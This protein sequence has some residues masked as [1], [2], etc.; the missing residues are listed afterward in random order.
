MWGKK[1]TT[2]AAEQAN[3]K[4]KQVEALR[5][6]YSNVKEVHRDTVY[7]VPLHPPVSLVLT[8][9]DGFPTTPPV[10]TVTPPVSHHWVD[11]NM[12]II[13]CP[14]L[15]EWSST[16]DLSKIVKSVSKEFEKTPPR[17]LPNNIPQPSL[18]PMLS[19]NGMPQPSGMMPQ[20]SGMYPNLAS[21]SSSNLR[22]SGG[23]SMF[24]SAATV[25]PAYPPL[26]P[27]P[28]EIFPEL[29]SLSK[30]ELEDLLS[31]DE[32]FEIFLSN[33]E[34]HKNIETIVKDLRDENDRVAAV[35][36]EKQE[37]LGQLQESLQLQKDLFKIKQSELDEK[38]KKLGEIMK[39]YSG[40]VIMGK[41]ASETHR[42][43]EESEDL[44]Q[45]FLRG[46]IEINEFPKV[47]IEARK[48]FH[49]RAAKMEMLQADP[50]ILVQK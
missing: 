24:A 29:V 27:K 23:Q 37:E 1:R 45:Q 43:E 47:F 32:K 28:A 30:Q 15:K 41:L 46:E 13:G 17:I 3:L 21:G 42:V 25:S 6:A 10:V 40:S 20:S 50:S 26:P 16:M 49:R 19:P 14:K 5:S 9:N 12:Y 2:D 38:A 4:R 31:D 36:L 8:L 39:K 22:P 7:E 44:A 35:T 34:K 11:P 48:R 18:Y 33:L